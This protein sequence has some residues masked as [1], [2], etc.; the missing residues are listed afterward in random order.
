MTTTFLIAAMGVEVVDCRLR[1]A[2]GHDLRA[3]E[4]VSARDEIAV[5]TTFLTARPSRGLA[6]IDGCPS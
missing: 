4:P 2:R 5:P 1:C 3:A 6:A